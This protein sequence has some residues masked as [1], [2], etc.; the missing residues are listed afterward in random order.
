M[1]IDLLWLDQ[2]LKR[3]NTAVGEPLLGWNIP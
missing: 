2:T 3:S 1:S